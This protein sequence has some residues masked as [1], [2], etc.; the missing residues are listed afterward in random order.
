MKK[1][2]FTTLISFAAILVASAQP[3]LPAKC[4]AKLPK[5]LNNIIISENEANAILK[6]GDYG[7]SNT[8][9]AYWT[10]YSDRENNTT[11][12]S[13]STSS[14]KCSE[15][16]WN[17]TV[18][19]AKIQGNFALVYTEP[20]RHEQFPLISADAVCRGWIEMK[21]LLL[22]RS[23]LANHDGIYFKALLCVNLEAGSSATQ[24][25]GKGYKAPYT[26]ASKESLTT[27][28]NFYYVMKY[29][30]DMA[31]LATQSRMDGKVSDQVLFCWVPKQSYVPW[32]QRSCLEPTWKHDDVEYFASKNITATVYE[33]VAQTKRASTIEYHKKES[34]TYDQYLYRMKGS[35]LRYPVLDNGTD[36]VYNMSTFSVHGGVVVGTEAEA[37]ETKRADDIQKEKLEKM[38]NINLVIVIDGTDSMAPYYPAVQEA[39]K[40][41]LEYFSQSYKIKVG[42]VIYRDYDDGESGL[43]EMIPLTN[44]SNGTLLARVN[45]FLATGGKYGIKSAKSDMTQTEALYYGMGYALDNMRF[46]DGE[47]N[48]MLVVG[49][50]G[51]TAGDTKCPTPDQLIAKIVE[52]DIHMMG[53]QVQNKNI[54]AFNSFNNQLLPIMRNSLSNHYKKYDSAIRVSA[55]PAKNEAGADE[56]YNFTANVDRQLYISSHRFAD[57]NINDGKMDPKLLTTHMTGSIRSFAE[58]IQG[59][60]DLIVAGAKQT[61]KRI[62]T[63]SKFKG[64]MAANGMMNIDDAFIASRLGKDWAEQLKNS[65]NVL[66]F[67]GYVKKKDA[68]DRDF[69]KPVIFISMEEFDELLK[70]LAPVAESALNSQ[71]KDRTPYIEAMKA[72]VRSFNPGITESDMAKL[73]N[74][75][76][77]KMIGGLSEASKSLNTYTIESLSDPIA[78]PPQKYLSI[79]TDFSRKYKNLSRIRQSRT[80]KYVKEFNSAKYYWIPI[81]DLP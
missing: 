40:S 59:Q 43:V 18:R 23:C 16:K 20:N 71:T 3:N 74:E 21:K 70:R 78:V 79:I 28:M 7:Q 52:K 39:I 53:F 34:A 50:C 30:N 26:T 6:S 60:I 37:P 44:V 80:Y 62:T 17:E 14:E 9:D 81:E 10:A 77:T 54:V 31:L 55:R 27:D 2:F 61:A 64:T 48:I 73:T 25:F 57:A 72:L 12:M 63:G 1:I 13:P 68:S 66:N 41:G 15:L 11:Y 76:I 8:I 65:G 51:N 49:D 67:S 36:S 56:G 19:I 42:V 46:A 22:W 38:L 32:N 75:E 24:D 58:T 45:N 33:D 47:S 29:D 69:F 35:D 4:I 5:V